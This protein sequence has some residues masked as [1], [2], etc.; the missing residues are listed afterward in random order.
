MPRGAAIKPLFQKGPSIGSRILLL[1]GLALLLIAGQMR[2]QWLRGIEDQ[3]A[4]FATPFY[5]L[6]DAPY[7]L[8]DWGSHNLQDWRSLVNDNEELRKE[9][10]ILKAKVAKMAA[11]SAENPNAAVEIVWKV[12]D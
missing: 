9:T 5:W 8:K 4:V 10:L 3:L 12:V 7:R 6:A 11:L 2:W 1:S